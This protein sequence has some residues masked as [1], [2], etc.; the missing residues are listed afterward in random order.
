MF[1][2]GMLIFLCSRRHSSRQ[3][4]KGS[5]CP[6]SHL[7][8]FL[9]IYPQ[10]E[11]LMYALIAHYPQKISRDVEEVQGCTCILCTVSHIGQGNSK[12]KSN[13]VMLTYIFYLLLSWTFITCTLNTLYPVRKLQLYFIFFF[14]QNVFKYGY[15]YQRLRIFAGIE[16]LISE[17]VAKWIFLNCGK[18]ERL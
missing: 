17:S 14:V 18:L 11:V 3:F 5:R 15:N 9:T 16:K 1:C 12:L 2:V 10:L 4:L 8:N 13:E 7:L 6:A